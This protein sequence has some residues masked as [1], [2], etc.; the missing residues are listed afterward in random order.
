MN[1]DYTLMSPEDVFNEVE[2]TGRQEKGTFGQKI[3]SLVQH[4]SVHMR[5][6]LIDTVE[7]IKAQK[8]DM[9]EKE[10][11]EAYKSAFVAQHFSQTGSI[12]PMESFM[13]RKL[14]PGM[15]LFDF[16]EGLRG[17]L[18]NSRDISRMHI[19]VMIK[20]KVL[21]S[22]PKNISC[23]L[24][25]DPDLTVDEIVRRGQLL[26]DSNDTSTCYATRDEL[27]ELISQI[28]GLLSE[29][30]NRSRGPDV[31]H[32]YKCGGKHRSS[33][34]GCTSVCYNCGRK[35]H[36]AKMC[37]AQKKRVFRN[38]AITSAEV[39]SDDNIIQGLVDTGSSDSLINVKNTKYLQLVNIHRQGDGYTNYRVIRLVFD[40]I[41]ALDVAIQD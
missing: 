40:Q 26:L 41:G 33:D 22:L 30:V 24:K 34:C 25:M 21:G 27:T 20:A 38:A 14:E 31:V 10:E 16:V 18:H 12:N 39:D 32:C 28:K 3:G 4:R 9:S 23:H 5:T 15:K 2:L 13:Q 1:T 36:L 8:P 35:G 19:D 11:Y 7:A 37:R 29:N 17:L 6:R